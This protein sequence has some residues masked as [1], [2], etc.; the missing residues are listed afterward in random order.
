MKMKIA[1]PWHPNKDRQFADEYNITFSN[2]PNNFENLI[3]FLSNHPDERFNITIDTK[4]YEFDF[5][6]DFESS[7]SL[8]FRAVDDLDRW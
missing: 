1:L 7:I 8:R 2:K 4:E 6:D 5:N 3:E